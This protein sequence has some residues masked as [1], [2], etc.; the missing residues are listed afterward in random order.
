MS[1]ST[2]TQF[3]HVFQ[4]KIIRSLLVEKKFLQTIS[5][6]LKVNETMKKK[7][8]TSTGRRIGDT[9]L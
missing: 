3:G 8:E 2:L 6:I 1:E 9:R 4:A 5:D 7:Q